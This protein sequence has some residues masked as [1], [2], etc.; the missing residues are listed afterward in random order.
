MGFGGQERALPH[1]QPLLGQ[2]GLKEKVLL[3]PSAEQPQGGTASAAAWLIRPLSI[4]ANDQQMLD[5]LARA[6]R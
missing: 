2:E 1:M 3:Q 5:G 4:S 6:L